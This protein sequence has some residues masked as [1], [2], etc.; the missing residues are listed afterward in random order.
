MTNAA[1]QRSLDT[2]PADQYS[3]DFSGYGNGIT[4]ATVTAQYSVNDSWPVNNPDDILLTIPAPGDGSLS[5]PSQVTSQLTGDTIFEV[6]A[7]VQA[8]NATTTSATIVGDSTDTTS[9]TS[10]PLIGGEG[11]VTFAAKGTGT[12]TLP[13][14]SF[15]ITPFVVDAS[16]HATQQNAITC[17]TN[18]A[19]Q[20]VKITVGAATGSFYMCTFSVSGATQTESSPFDMAVTA[21]GNRTVG[22]TD[23]VKLTS[24]G[25]AVTGLTAGVTATFS[26]SLEVQ[27][28]QSGSVSLT[29]TQTDQS[30]GPLVA[31]G[32]LHLSKA[33]TI[34]LLIPQTFTITVSAQ[35]ASSTISCALQ[36]S[37][38]P[39]ALTMSVANAS[40]G[41]GSGTTEGSGTPAGSPA[42]GGGLGPASDDTA[43]AAGAGVALIAV[44]GVLLLWA[45]RR[46]AAELPAGGSWRSWRRRSS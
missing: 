3:C 35:G 8:Q 19:A 31:T 1:S 18:V 26:G 23:S 42:T 14:A 28:A 16:G 32:T 10:V 36:T 30:S 43:A 11:Q 22:A 25:L 12:V 34:R 13:P 38:A 9:P 27:G 6:T 5:L 4:P 7:T 39:T 33:G 29:G 41:G 20:N 46:R 15:A 24:T 40:G 2:L 45:R 21:S 17:T 44:G 37:P